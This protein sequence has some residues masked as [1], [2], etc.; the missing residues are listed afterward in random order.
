M[1]N[2]EAALMVDSV[3]VVV[4]VVDGEEVDEDDIG[5]GVIRELLL[6]VKP[7]RRHMKGLF[8]TTDLVIPGS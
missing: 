8:V 4:G 2:Q 6:C 1:G 5:V 3:L 7:S